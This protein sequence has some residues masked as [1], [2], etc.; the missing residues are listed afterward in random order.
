M[1]VG[2]WIGVNGLIK[3]FPFFRPTGHFKL[4]HI[5]VSSPQLVTFLVVFT[6]SVVV[7]LAIAS[8]LGSPNIQF[9]S[10]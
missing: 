10:C 4:Q 2:A 5:S 3:Y 9:V 8:V 7:V 1:A 6:L